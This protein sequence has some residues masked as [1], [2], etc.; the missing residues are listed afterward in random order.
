MK[1]RVFV[2]L[3]ST[4]LDPQGQTVC[5]ALH[6]LGYADIVDVRQGKFFD[7]GIAAGVTRG[8]GAEGYRNH[9][10]RSAGQPR[11]RRVPHRNNRWVAFCAAETADGRGSAFYNVLMCGI[12]GYIGNRRAVPIILEGLKRLEYRGYDSAGL[13]VYCDDNQ[14]ARA[15]RPGQA[16]QPGRRHPPEPGGWLLRHRPHP[17]GHARAAHR[18]ERAPAPRLPRRRGGG[19]QRHR[20]KLPAAQAPARRPRATSSRPKPTPKSSRTWWRSISTAT[21]KKPC[22]RR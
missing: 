12:V 11:D 21:W 22:A 15:P 1:A 20:R 19:A 16:A 6:G 2:S 18:R 3:K 8:A 10:A 17:L 4:V 7:I 13:A 9:R 5:S 14:L